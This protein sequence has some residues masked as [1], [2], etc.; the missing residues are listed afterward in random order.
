MSG[1]AGTD[2]PRGPR[3]PEVADAARLNNARARRERG[4]TLIEGPHLLADAINAGVR[5]GTVFASPGD[6]ESVLRAE[7]HGLRV[8]AVSEAAMQR[9]ADTRT[10]RGP[11]AVVDIP[12]PRPDPGLNLLVSYGVSEPGNVGALI[13]TSA[14]FGWGFAYTPGSGDPW[15]PKTLRAG[16]GGHFR[17]AVASVSGLD[18][19]GPWHTVATVVTGANPPDTLENGPYALLI[20]AEAHGLPP[21]VVEAARSRVTIP[22][23]G[24]TESLNASV[25]AGILVYA[26]SAR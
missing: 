25:A 8:V 1:D 16:A 17:T 5:V 6:H 14:A 21:E 10:P 15:S 19:L 11:V 2:T 3:N 20:G 9:L 7:K 18:A 4:Q 23:P 24:G 13:R 22:M 26:L 12:E